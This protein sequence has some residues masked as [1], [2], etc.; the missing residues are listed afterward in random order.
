MKTHSILI[1]SVILVVSLM[2]CDQDDFLSRD[3]QDV[4]LEDQVWSNPD[5]VRSNLASLYDSKPEYQSLEQYWNF[6][7]FDE[8]FPS[9]NG[10]YWRVRRQTYDYGAWEY[11]DYGYIHN[12]NLF[13]ARAEE[14]GDQLDPSQLN[15]FVSEARF[16]RANAYFE[17]VKRM[18]GVPLLT[19][20]L[21][22]QVGENPDRLYKPRAAEAEVYD[23]IISEMDDI[24]SDLPTDPSI[25]STATWGAAMA[26]KSRAALYAASIARYGANTPSVSLPNNEVGIPQSRADGYYQTALDAASELIGSNRYSLYMKNPNDLSANFTDL[27]RDKQNNPEVIWAKDYLVQSETHQFT[28]NS[29]PK[30]LTE[31]GAVAGF[32]NP[33]LNLVQEFELL[34]NTF[35]PLQN[36]DS[37]GDL[38]AYDNKGE[39]FANRDARLAGTVM[40]PGSQFKGQDLDIWAG[41]M[42]TDGTITSGDQF[43][44]RK[45]LPGE[46]EP[47]QVVGF[48]GPID[49][50]E[51]GTQTGFYIRKY[52][53]PD[54]AAGR[55]GTGSEIWWIHYRLGEIYLNAA[56]AAHELGDNDMAA[57][58]INEVRQRAGFS[59]DLEPGEITF[60]RIVHER[61]VELAFEGHQLWDYKRWRIAHQVWN[62]APIDIAAD[63][64]GDA[65]APS[66]GPIGLWPYKIHNPGEAD[67]GDWVFVERV[68]SVVTNAVTFRLGNYYSRI[69]PGVLSS[70]PELVQNP[71]Q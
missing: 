56:E 57:D 16:L 2:S 71:N 61:K 58:Y 70:N 18:G 26:M 12:I 54:P 66:T 10:D 65:T 28:V 50:L 34:D 11:W 49:Q 41:V 59:D 1:L 47:E 24:A 37:N 52:L 60:D 25:K 15:Q 29:Q 6:T 8:A 20:T 7:D 3:P 19:D 39:I 67:D 4:L 38:I 23:F 44:Q 5:L 21:N 9:R 32:V 27:F 46:S 63:T 14:N 22:Y 62:G 48:D 42:E 30:S 45:T 17:M 31:E 51:L 43:G 68:P 13:L 33:S 55:I 64:P 35:E 53:D 69:N 40:L 36:R